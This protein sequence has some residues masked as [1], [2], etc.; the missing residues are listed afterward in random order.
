MTV[1]NDAAERTS[2]FMKNGW[3]AVVLVL[4]F[5]VLILLTSGPHGRGGF[6]LDDA[7]IHMVYGRSIS[8]SGYLAYN[9]GIPATGSTSPLWAYLLG[10]IHLV[11]RKMSLIVLVVK[12]T[13]MVLHSLAAWACFRILKKFHLPDMISLIGGL[14]MGLSPA[15]IVAS[16][17]GMEIPLGYLLCLL[18]FSQYIE[19]RYWTTGILLGLAGLARPEFG[20]V[21]AVLLGDMAFQI[22]KKEMNGKDII[23]FAVP[24]IVAGFL[25]IAWNLIVDGRPFPATFYLKSGLFAHFSILM[26]VQSAFKMITADAPLAGGVAW[27]GLFGLALFR[28]PERRWFRVVLFSAVLYTLGQV[29]IIPPSDPQ[30]FYHI[31]YLLPAIPLFWAAL[32][33]GVWALVVFL[34]N[35]VNGLYGKILAGGLVGISVFAMAFFLI[36][37]N[38]SW[39]AKYANDCRNIDEVQVALGRAIDSAF[40]SGARIGTVDAGAI[41]YFGRR[42]TVDLMG[43]NAPRLIQDR[44]M[45]LNALVLIPAW[46]QGLQDSGLEEVGRRSTVDY[47]VT[48]N[49]AM[50]TQ[51]VMACRMGR[52]NS[53]IS[54]RLSGRKV[55]VYMKCLSEAQ[56]EELKISL[57]AR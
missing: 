52:E 33:A 27:L 49:P 7:W 9:A 20:L 36:L 18:G 15:L 23:Q 54:L 56:I 24:A 25:F 6:P 53:E 22:L 10:L 28:K 17:S 4:S 8:T 51:I 42:F 35:Q 31:R 1:R 12:M 48:S 26:R 43:L 57:K 21:I 39:S 47:G 29:M 30:A 13:G 44:A 45:P 37:G 14:I 38:I 46:I 32:M 50:N 3:L 16:I 40:A 41:K 2:R 5:A 55:I 19:K 34:W 11:F